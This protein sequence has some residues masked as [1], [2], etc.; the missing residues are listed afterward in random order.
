MA[1]ATEVINGAFQN[2]AVYSPSDTV[3]P[4]DTSVGLTKLNDFLNGLNSRGCTFETVALVSTD[5]VPVAD[6]N[7][8]DLKWCLAKVMAPLYGKE[9]TGG[10]L[11]EARTAERRFI[12]SLTVLLPAQADGGLLNMPGQRRWW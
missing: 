9:L 12:A 3:A 6:Q 11:L 7:I 4:E 2:L 8:A 1:T 5:T 10:A